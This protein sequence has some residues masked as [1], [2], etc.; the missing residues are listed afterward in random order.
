MSTPKPPQAPSVWADRRIPVPGLLRNR[1]PVSDSLPSAPAP[2]CSL[3][4]SESHLSV[5]GDSI[6]SLYPNC[7]LTQHFRAGRRAERVRSTGC[8]SGS[9]GFYSQHPHGTSQPC[10]TPVPK[11]SP[12]PPW[13]RFYGYCTHVVHRHTCRPKKKKKIRAHIE[14]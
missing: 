12:L 7:T 2:F 5:S 14:N 11:G 1:C 6:H 9:L 13:V 3:L 10:V 8:S 4:W